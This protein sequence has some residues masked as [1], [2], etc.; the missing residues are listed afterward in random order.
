MPGCGFLTMA[1]EAMYQKHCALLQPEDAAG[2]A[3]NDLCYRFRNVHFNRAMVLAEEKELEIISTLTRV[4]GDK[5]WHEFRISTS[6]ADV[7]A[8]HCFGL[9]RIQDAVEERLEGEHAAPLKLPQDPKIWFKSN[10]D[11]GSDFGPTFRRLIEYEA[12]NGQRSARSLMSLSPPPSKYSPQS[13]YPVHPAALDGCLQTAIISN[14]MC[15]RTKVKSVMVPSLLDDLIINKVP[16]HLHEGR[17]ISESVFSGRGRV[18]EEKSWVAN[19]STYDAE[20]GNLVVRF[21]G[22]NY[23]KLDVAPRP[24]PHTFHC[25]SWKPDITFFD[26]DQMMHLEPGD[27]S[28]KVDT[29]IDMVAHKKPSLNVLEVSLDENNPSCIWFGAGDLSARGAYTRYEFGSPNADALVNVQTQYESKENSSFLTIDPEKKALGLTVGVTYDLVIV[30]LPETKTKFSSEDL[31]RNSQPLLS[32]GAFTVV[33]RSRDEEAVTSGES[34]SPGDFEHLKQ[35]PSPE[36][37]TTPSQSSGSLIDGLSSSISP[38]WNDEPGKEAY[39]SEQAAEKISRIEI[40]AT[41]RSNPASLWHSMR[42]HQDTGSRGTLFVVRLAET[43]PET[44]P[45]ELQSLLEDSG[46]TIMRQS[47]PSLKPTDGSVVLV[48]DELWSPVLTQVDENQWEAI[49]GLVRSGN[50]LLWVTKGAQGSATNPDAAMIHGLFRVARQE[51]SSAKLTT[52]DVQSSASPATCW[53]IERVLGAIRRGDSWETEYMERDSLL[54]IPRILPDTAVNDFKAAEKEGLEPVIKDFH[55]N[56]A[57]VQLR[58]ERLGTLQDLTWCET[59]L[60]EGVVEAGYVEVE[61]VAAGVNFK[62]VAITM[63]IVPDDEYNLGLE[64]GGVVRRLG[65]DVKK[66]TPGDRVCLLGAGSFANRIRV[67]VERCHLIPASMSFEEAATIPSVYLCSIYAMY[68]LG[69]LKEGQVRIS[70]YL[71]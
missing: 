32:A 16:S 19:T 5:N 13:Y 24:D 44:L 70:T 30:N 68:H 54:Y 1:V 15:D 21:T 34:S 43:T 17:S 7:V 23:V 41:H 6:Q 66:F 65:A 62:D 27:A 57:R 50:P 2:I 26:Q 51:D 38:V 52:L 3:P 59:E 46:W 39:V 10:R 36:S 49:K 37:P 42:T 55:A 35:V 29:V 61:V 11:W 53:A 31:V 12:I 40:P 20:G 47:D 18:D 33:V 67:P 22:L 60:K 9:V 71:R 8:E 58:A 4:P 63:G 64:C 69:N 14:V 56:E 28:N 45:A 25:I 48:L